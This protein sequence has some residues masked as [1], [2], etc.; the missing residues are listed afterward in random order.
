[1]RNERKTVS[2]H[3]RKEYKMKTNYK[4]VL[5]LAAMGFALASP[6]LAGVGVII[7][8]PSI[9][10][11]PP[12]VVVSPPPPPVV[13]APPAVVVAPD[14]YV[15]DGTEYVGVVGDQYYYLGPGN[16]WV[17]MDPPRMHRFNVWIGAHPDWRSHM[18][19][20]VHYRGNIGHPQPMHDHPDHDHNYNN[21]HHGPPQ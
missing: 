19:A 5:A 2:Q 4:Y 12:A 21:D 11:S 16:V 9:V 8:G 1:M 14:N 3:G 10:V 17:A 20:N 13:V 18:T 15:W 6:C 7:G